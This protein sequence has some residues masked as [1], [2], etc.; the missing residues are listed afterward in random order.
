MLIVGA[1]ELVGGAGPGADEVGTGGA[2]G[3][4][5]VGDGL[6]PELGEELCR[7]SPDAAETR[8]VPLFA[9]DITAWVYEADAAVAETIEELTVPLTEAAG[10]T[11]VCVGAVVDTAVLEAG[12][13]TG[14]GM[15]QPDGPDDPRAKG[16]PAEEEEVGAGP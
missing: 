11:V 12:L 6:P 1:D 2:V 15:P 10:C 16:G 9:G 4:T 5:R 13:E 8:T 7:G 3:G 14:A